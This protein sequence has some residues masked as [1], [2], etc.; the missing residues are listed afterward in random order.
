MIKENILETIGNTPLVKL[1]KM[2][3]ATSAIYAKVEAFN[4]MLSVKDRAAL[5]MIEEAEK[6]GDINEETLIVEP[7]SGN[8][9]IG[10]SLLC[11]VKGYRL[12]I[13]MPD[14]MSIERRKTIKA[15]GAELVLTPGSEGM[16]GAIAKAKE[17]ANEN[18]NSFMP[19][20]FSNP[21]NALAHYKTTGPEIVNDLNGKIDY[22]V[23]GVGSG[24]TLTGVAKYF[25]EKNIDAKIIA[26]EPDTSPVLST[27]VAGAHKIQGLGA[28]FVPELLDVSLIDEVIRVTDKQ[29][30]DASRDAAAK[31]G[32]FVGISSGAALAAAK[33]IASREEAN[34]KNIVVVLPD[35]GDRYLSTWLWEIE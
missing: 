32:L 33:E 24:G 9:G 22:F 15:F 11:A 1:N 18:K 21:D 27:G 6:R 10:L 23:S 13:V 26:V 19:M 4:P 17:I 12:I 16:K 2:N 28:G 5:F 20:Q 35:S 8:T 34:G 30:G 29:A 25:K 31:E 3:S 14:T 7:T